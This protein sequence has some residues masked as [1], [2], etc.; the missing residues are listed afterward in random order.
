MATTGDFVVLRDHY[1]HQ[2]VC[3]RTVELHDSTLTV[4]LAGQIK[5]DANLSVQQ[6]LLDLLDEHKPKCM[7]LD[8]HDVTFVDSQGL[9]MILQAHH[10]C[11]A[12]GSLLSVRDPNPFLRDLLRLTRIDTYLN[13]C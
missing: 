6:F 13:L 12:A 4:T 3:A 8:C 9:S 1:P 10:A 2:D 5:F 7:I 11:R